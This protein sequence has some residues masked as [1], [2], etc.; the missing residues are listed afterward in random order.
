MQ[1]FLGKHAFDRL[2][3]LLQLGWIE[4]R[5]RQDVFV[6]FLKLVDD[7]LFLDL[8]P[9]LEGDGLDDGVFFEIYLYDL[10]LVPFLL[11][12]PDIGEKAGGPEDFEVLF[13][14]I[15]VEIIPLP[16]R[17]IIH[18]R[19]PGDAL[20]ADDVD[21]FDHF[22]TEGQQGSEEK[23]QPENPFFHNLILI[24]QADEVFKGR[25]AGKGL[26]TL[27]KRRLQAVR[28][29]SPRSMIYRFPQKSA[30]LSLC[31][32]MTEERPLF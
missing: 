5:I 1:A 21:P 25:G 10:A 3:D 11:L 32:T 16:G 14:E 22:L 30:T 28:F 6:L 15:F 7:I 19:F 31:V 20:V 9:R 4:I 24:P 17:Q 29:N 8:G 23:E 13:Q 26:D 27:L 18:D 12:D 2:F